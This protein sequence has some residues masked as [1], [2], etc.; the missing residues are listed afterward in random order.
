MIR[1]VT[2]NTVRGREPLEVPTSHLIGSH[3]PIIDAHY[4]YPLNGWLYLV[5]FHPQIIKYPSGMTYQQW[6]F[7]EDQLELMFHG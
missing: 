5:D 2:N 7:H 3:G 6:Y 4:S 1:E